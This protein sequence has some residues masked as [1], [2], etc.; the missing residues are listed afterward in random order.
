MKKLLFFSALLLNASL[1]HAEEVDLSELSCLNNPIC[2]SCSQYAKFLFPI[3]EYSSELDAIEIEAD[4]SEIIGKDTFHI[5]GNVQAKSDKYVL[6]ADEVKFNQSEQSSLAKGNVKFQDSNWLLTS[7]ELSVAKNEYGVTTS[8]T[9]SK[10]QN[11]KSRAHGVA[12]FMLKEPESAYLKSATYSLCPIDNNDWFIRADSISLDLENNRGIANKATMNF[13]GIPIVY[14]PKYSWVIDGRGSGFLTPYFD[15]YTES[16]TKKRTF[17]SRI[18][19]Y[20]NLAPDRDLLLALSYMASRGILYEGK[21]RRLIAPS[22]NLVGG[23]FDFEAQYLFQDKLSDTNRWLIDTS[24]ELDISEKTHLNVLYNEVSDVNYFKDITRGNTDIESLKS[25]IELTYNNPP[26]VEENEDE[27]ERKIRLAKYQDIDYDNQLSISILSETEQVVNNGGD[28]YTKPF[29][30]SIEREINTDKLPL[31]L[32]LNFITTNF[33]NE[34]IDKTTGN[35]THAEVELSKTNRMGPFDLKTKANLGLTQYFLDNNNNQSR[36]INGY[37]IALSLPYEK[38]TTLFGYEVIHK[39]TPR[40]SYDFTAKKEQKDLPIFDTSDTINNLLT[41][42]SLITGDRY[43]GLDRIVNEN[44]ITISL[45]SKYEDQ[46][47]DKQLNQG[48]LL[49]FKIAQRFYGDDEVVSIADDQVT[50]EPI[51]FETRRTYSDIAASIELEVDDYIYNT[52]LQ[53]DPKS[54]SITKKEIGFSYIPQ[55]RKLI[56]LSYSDDNV[57]ESATLSAAYP[58]TDAIHVF[59]GLDKTLS[60]GV[61]NKETVGIAYESCCW[62]ARLVNFKELIKNNDYNYSLGFELVFK[63]IGSVDASLTNHIENNIPGYKAIIAE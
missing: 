9:N 27:E 25:N 49:N 17:R 59:A 23:S 40:I 16:T 28:E 58:L 46:T 43:S 45:E 21:Y 15:L 63:G 4:H 56:S 42:N 18:P 60:S 48:T 2:K 35:R 55:S 6:L 8:S 26:L 37:G 13:L 44:D 31:Q 57:T 32:D 34:R 12:D 11:L 54:T 5:T 51:N 14:F 29:E 39:L 10:Y 53:F 3:Q 62:G 22:K 61:T 7:N 52:R 41:F 36:T 30:I 20:F 33:A 50:Y 19:Y 47:I 38:E 24:L 1:I